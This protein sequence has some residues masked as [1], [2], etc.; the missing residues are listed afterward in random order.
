VKKIPRRELLLLAVAAA[1]GLA[2][3]LIYVRTTLG[4]ALAGDE[5]E[6]DK[7]AR[8]FADGHFMW[9]TTPY[10]DPHPTMVKAPL[11]P[12][13]VGIQ[14]ALLGENYDRVLTLQ[15]LIGPV[16]IVLTWVLARRL[17]NPTVALAAAF[18]V[19]VYP[20]AWQFE[21]RLYS[22][23]IT[24]PLV[25]VALI[26]F[27]DREPTRVRVLLLGVTVGLL[28]LSRPAL[29]YLLVGALVCW[30][31]IA[32]W[33]KG[34]LATAAA[35]AVALLVV[36]P[37]TLRNYLEYDSF[38]LVSWQDAAAVYGTFNDEAANDDE[39]PYAWRTTNA[40]DAPLFEP[41]NR[42]EE[43]ELRDRLN[44]NAVEWIKDHPDALPK[45]F[46]WNGLTR[47]WDIRRPS[48]ALSEVPHEGRSRFLT[49]VGLGM[50]YVLLPL[51]VLLLF[52]ARRRRA[53]VLPVA[54]IALAASLTHTIV[55]LTRY[56]SVIEPLIVVLACGAVALLLE[57]RRTERPA[58]VSEAA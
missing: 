51:A 17:F 2:L 43:D 16:V 31:L 39:A 22:E 6:Y 3:R 8:L 21:A 11:Y 24:T 13:L 44:D 10:G 4:H 36:S 20:F 37:W 26:L 49:K 55:S 28:M 35:G 19:A 7:I 54:A 48:T 58:A 5:I 34:I 38:V 32:G 56:R 12:V 47:F 29:V 33:K 15:T 52:L 27:L 30:V 41:R 9:S 1:L 18:L 25:L 45:A 53:L 50:Y 40:R 46:F 23:A 14:Y 42:M 57:R